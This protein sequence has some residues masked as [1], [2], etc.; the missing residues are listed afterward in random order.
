MKTILFNLTDGELE[1]FIADMGQ[2]RF[3]AKQIREWLNR[4]AP[5]FMSMKNI[6]ESLRAELDKVAQT[7]PVKIIKKLEF[8]TE[9]NYSKKLFDYLVDK[10]DF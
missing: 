9:G 3:R 10:Y 7:L 1:K 4:G 8:D 5:D 2:P 6:P